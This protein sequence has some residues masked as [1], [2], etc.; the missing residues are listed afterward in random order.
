MAYNIYCL[1]DFLLL[2]CSSD[3][4]SADLPGNPSDQMPDCSGALPIRCQPYVYEEGKWSP[5]RLHN[6]LENLFLWFPHCF[7]HIHCS[8]VLFP[9][10]AYR[11][12]AC[13]KDFGSKLIWNIAAR[14]ENS[15][16]FH[17][18][19]TWLVEDHGDFWRLK[20]S[21]FSLSLPGKSTHDSF[22]SPGYSDFM[23]C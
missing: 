7:H 18:L 13:L 5:P 4:F 11:R 16:H 10:T 6:V 14:Y 20:S 19:F 3:C 12:D 1:W 15:I 2:F 8:H 17:F 21:D 23:A 22:C 9:C